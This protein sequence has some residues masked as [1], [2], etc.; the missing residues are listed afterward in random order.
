MEV[1]SSIL[2]S[3]CLT[4]NVVREIENLK[5]CLKKEKILVSHLAYGDEDCSEP[6]KTL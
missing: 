6:N 4:C 1:V 3:C 2:L 5:I